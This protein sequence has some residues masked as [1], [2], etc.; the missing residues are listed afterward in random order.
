MISSPSQCMHLIFRTF[1]A[2]EAIV[3]ISIHSE[4]EQY[5][6]FMPHLLPCAEYSFLRIIITFVMI[7]QM[8]IIR[9]RAITK[10]T[11]FLNSSP[12]SCSCEASIQIVRKQQQEIQACELEHHQSCTISFEPV[13]QD[14]PISNHQALSSKHKDQLVQ[15]SLQFLPKSVPDID[16]KIEWPQEHTDIQRPCIDY[17]WRSGGQEEYR[18]LRLASVITST[19]SQH[20]GRNLDDSHTFDRLR[21]QTYD[22]DVHHLICLTAKGWI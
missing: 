14:S 12:C 21:T 9:S 7:C 19:I 4:V 17:I 15:T 18:A 5:K 22:E 6:A 20:L 2:V 16:S 8:L 10:L 3:M 13:Q 1:K 11:I